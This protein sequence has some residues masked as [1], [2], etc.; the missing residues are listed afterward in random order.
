MAA[1]RTVRPDA[2]RFL[3]VL[4]LVGCLQ[5]S[6]I[7]HAQQQTGADCNEVL[8][9]AEAAKKAEIAII[10][11]RERLSASAVNAAKS[12]IDRVL[13]ALRGMIPGIPGIQ[14]IALQQIIDALSN[15]ICTVVQNKATD[16]VGNIVNPINDTVG[17]VVGGVNGAVGGAGGAVGI[18]APVV[19]TPGT[20]GTPWGGT[21]RAAAG[22]RAPQASSSVWND[23]ACRMGGGANCPTKN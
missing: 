14:D 12:C 18:P 16:V 3:T 13:T 8:V 7:V 6:G 11:E 17:G 15:K 1:R 19:V 2:G 9:A 20:P 21:P 23:V 4:V 10:D 5:M 22:Q